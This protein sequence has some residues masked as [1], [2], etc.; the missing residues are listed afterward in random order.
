MNLSFLI[1]L[2]SVLYFLQNVVESKKSNKLIQGKDVSNTLKKKPN[3]NKSGKKPNK[4]KPVKKPTKKKTGKKP[5]RKTTSKPS[6]KPGASYKS[7]YYTKQNSIKYYL[8]KKLEKKFDMT[9]NLQT[10]HIS[11]YTCLK[12]EKEKINSKKVD[13]Y[14]ASCSESWVKLS[15]KEGKPTKVCLKKDETENKLIFYFGYALGLVPEITRSDSNLH[16]KVLKENI[17][18]ISDY[19]KYY[20]VQQ[21]SST[22][23]ANSSFDYYSKMFSSPYFKSKGKGKR[24]Y[25]FLSD[26]GK[27]YEKTAN[28]SGG[29]SHNDFKRLWYLYCNKKCTSLNCTNYGYPIRS[30]KKCRCPSPFYGEKC[31]KLYR[32]HISCGN[33]QEFI[34]NSSKSFYTIKNTNIICSYSIKSKNGKKVQ[35]NIENLNKS[36]VQDCNWNVNLIVKYRE[37]KGAGGLSLCGNYTNISFPPL[38]S[39]V[40]LIYSGIG[41][42]SLHFS[43]KEQ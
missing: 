26:L 15:T 35:F 20:K 39:E 29:F 14:I 18:P 24:T 41:R 2:I 27:Y 11:S 9:I 5:K 13:I 21:Y 17:S 22:I 34:A 25:T 42:G 16:V 37:D 32:N 28:M 31:E 23:I 43:I 1:I 12:I 4:K 8:D 38:S 10:S 33:T 36:H 7:P 6:H 30:C 40:Y 19:E 3:K